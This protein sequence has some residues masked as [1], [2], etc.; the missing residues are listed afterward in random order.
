MSKELTP[1]QALE[2]LKGGYKNEDSIAITRSAFERN[3]AIIETALKKIEKPKEIV[4]T[5][6][7]DKALEQFLID[8]CPEV[9]KKLKALEI[10]K[11]K[12]VDINWLIRSKNYSKYN[13]GVGESQKLKKREY[14]LLKEILP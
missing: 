4:G 3:I 14:D 7:L 10:I 6:T 5:T 2:Q 9:K 8:N 11:T 13:L 1:L 12:N